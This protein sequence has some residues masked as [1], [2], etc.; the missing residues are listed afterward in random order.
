M[1]SAK[2]NETAK[3]APAGAGMSAVFNVTLACEG[4]SVPSSLG[5]LSVS[6]ADQSC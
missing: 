6:P 2:D 1:F 3:A 4:E 5:S